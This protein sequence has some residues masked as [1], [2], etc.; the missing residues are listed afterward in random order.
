MQITPDLL[1]QYFGA[2]SVVT[3]DLNNPDAEVK[4]DIQ[5]MPF[6]DSSF[7]I[8]MCYEVLDYIP[9]DADAISEIY[10]VLSNPGYALIRV[11]YLP[12]V[13]TVDFEVPDADDSNHI[14]R[15][16][17]DLLDRLKKPGFIVT[18]IRAPDFLSCD[19]V[20]EIGAE[21]DPL[22]LLQ[23]ECRKQG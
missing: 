20:A 22:F 15:Y 14:R 3:F 13:Q 2:K 5:R 23:K 9:N 18:E 10:R 7:D 16:G 1:R 6:L 8:V 17:K 12:A 11:G 21:Q 4:G 19:F